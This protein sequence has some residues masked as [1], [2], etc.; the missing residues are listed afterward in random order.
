MQRI[1]L[2]LFFIGTIWKCEAQYQWKLQRSSEGIKVFVSDVAG[3]SFKAVKV[4]C[5]FTGSYGKLISILTNVSQHNKWIYN[6]K[7]SYLLKKLGP[8]DIIYYSETSMPWPIS[9]RDAVIRLEISTENLPDH[10]TIT[11][12]GQPKYL[13]EKQGKVRV[14]HYVANWKVTMPTPQTISITYILQIDPGGIPPGLSN[15]FVDKGP[16]ETFK[17]LREMLKK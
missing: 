2:T 3:S 4:E 12:K 15:M 7:T 17:N 11:G 5:T 1:A 14:P 13:S 6:C 9:N 10:L 16:F 8:H